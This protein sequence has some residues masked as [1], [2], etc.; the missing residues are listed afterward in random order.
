MYG[1]H[2]GIGGGHFGV[3]KSVAKLKEQFY[4]PGHYNDVKNWCANCSSCLTRKTAP[5]HL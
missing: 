5:P 2:E 1:I 3:E 4:W